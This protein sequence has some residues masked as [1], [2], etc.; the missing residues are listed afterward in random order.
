MTEYDDYRSQTDL[1]FQE[2][3]DREQL[4]NQE[5]IRKKCRQRDGTDSAIDAVVRDLEKV[6]Q[7]KGKKTTA[8]PTLGPFLVRDFAVVFKFQA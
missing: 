4:A 5:E 8:R 6:A 2:M 7:I 3:R 1:I